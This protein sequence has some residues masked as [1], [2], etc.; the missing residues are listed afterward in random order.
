M[1]V[2]TIVAARVYRVE[3]CDSAMEEA[4]LRRL[5]CYLAMEE[6]EDDFALLEGWL[7]AAD[8]RWNS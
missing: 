3:S 2:T 5:D 7:S 4:E 6:E 8:S 1:R